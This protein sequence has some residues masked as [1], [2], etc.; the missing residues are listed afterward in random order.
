[1]SSPS[2]LKAFVGIILLANDSWFHS[3]PTLVHTL[4]D[5]SQR[6]RALKQARHYRSRVVAGSYNV[7]QLDPHLCHFDRS[8]VRRGSQHGFTLK[9]KLE[10]GMLTREDVFCKVVDLF[11]AQDSLNLEV[12][13]YATLKDLQGIA[14]PRVCG[15]PEP[16]GPLCMMTSLCCIVGKG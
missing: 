10:T 9:A 15:Y 5:L 11:R 2:M 16:I 3:S 8:S 4:V 7:L 1:M 13:N 6:D 12:S 14:I